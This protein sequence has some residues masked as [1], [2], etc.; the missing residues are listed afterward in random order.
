SLREPE[1]FELLVALSELWEAGIILKLAMGQHRF[2][3]LVSLSDRQADQ[4]RTQLELLA[5]VNLVWKEGP[6][7]ADDEAPWSLESQAAQIVPALAFLARAEIARNPDALARIRPEHAEAI[8]RLCVRR[9]HKQERHE[10]AG[11]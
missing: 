4:L 3:E 2:K 10:L 9:F 6:A 11:D 1:G 7:G 8:A 5:T